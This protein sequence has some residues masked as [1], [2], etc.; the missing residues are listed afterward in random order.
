MGGDIKTEVFFDHQMA[1]TDFNGV[2]V[3]GGGDH[4]AATSRNH[5]II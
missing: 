3:S 2:V 1:R 4:F 5:L